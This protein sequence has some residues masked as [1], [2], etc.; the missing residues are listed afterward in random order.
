MKKNDNLETAPSQVA[1][2]ALTAKDILKKVFACADSSTGDEILQHI[3]N[4]LGSGSATHVNSVG[5]ATK[6]ISPG[7]G[8]FLQK[9]R[10]DLQSLN[11]TDREDVE[12]AILSKLRQ[13]AKVRR[14]GRPKGA[15]GQDTGKQ[16][17]FSG[18]VANSWFFEDRNGSIS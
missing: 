7:A 18:C 11:E 17:H 2:G 10:S 3:R 5:A 15:K 1:T 9:F 6:L 16:I 8:E 13:S 12:L 14:G 4:V